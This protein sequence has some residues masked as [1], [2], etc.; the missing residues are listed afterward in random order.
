SLS[1]LII[2]VIVAIVTIC[3]PG[4]PAAAQQ[5]IL[6]FRGSATDFLSQN[7]GRVL[8]LFFVR[9]DCPVSNRYAPLIQQL[10]KKYGH[11]ASFRLV[12]PDRN[13]SQEKIRQFLRE[14][15]YDL[16]AI[17]DVDRTLARRTS[18]KVTPEAAVFDTKSE[19][20]YHGRIDNLYERI[21]Q[22][23]RAATKHELA[24]AIDA[25][26][27]GARIQTPVVDGVGCFISDLE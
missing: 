13:E 27:K 23:R 21:G 11:D 6:D 17:R 18:A 22:A 1:R 10:I 15:A 12:F 3:L 16:P 5:E 14:Y 8:V 9:T 19:L 26:I 2:V 7:R 25:A 20:V 4:K 24:D